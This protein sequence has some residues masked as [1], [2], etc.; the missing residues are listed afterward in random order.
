MRRALD[1]FVCLGLFLIFLLPIVVIIF[2]IKTTSRGPAIYWSNRVGKNNIL[3]KMPKFRTMYLNTPTVAT[4]LLKNPSLCLTPIGSFLRKTSLDEIPQLWSILIGDMSF[5]GPR[6][7][8]FN[9]YDLIELRTSK[10][11]HHLTPGLTG[12]SQVNGRDDLSIAKKVKFD[13]EYL[14]KKSFIFDMKILYLTLIKI[15]RREGIH[16]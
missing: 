1:L 13:V 10:G 4:H 2:S 11:V 7:A 5:I 16:H 15:I 6:P 9:Q 8:L 14:R 3:F 12:W